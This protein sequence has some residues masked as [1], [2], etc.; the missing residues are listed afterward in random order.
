VQRRNQCMLT[1]TAPEEQAEKITVAVT[2]Y[3]IRKYIGRCLNSVI[4]QSWLNLEIIVIDDGSTDGSENICDAFAAADPRIRVIHT[5]NGGPGQARNRAIAASTGAYVAFVDGD[6]YIEPQMYEIM[7][8]G[9]KETGADLSV[10]RYRCVADGSEQARALLTDVPERPADTT[11]AELPET[12]LVQFSR[13]ELLTELVEESD[14]YP[15]RNAVWNKLCRRELIGKLRLPAQMYYEDILFTM[16]L[17]AGAGSAC[18]IDTPLY[19]Y[20]ID[21]KGSIMNQGV[22]R[23][24]LTDQIPAY[25]AKEAFLSSIGREDLARTH[26]YLVCKKLLLLYTEARRSKDPEKQASLKALEKVIRTS[27]KDRR[28]F[29]CRIADPH[30]KLRMDL[31]QISPLLY[32]AFMDVNDG[33]VMPLRQAMK[34]SPAGRNGE[35]E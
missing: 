21:R 3:N 27:V 2:C 15:I 11:P 16:Q 13:D 10:C 25:D 20:I 28:I 24:I 5:E 12:D 19:N 23:G 22:N 30:Q 35:P 31:F 18:F 14:R 9:M 34:K 7:L 17:L 1:K 33:L 6:D 4:R 29:S 8:A 26:R 32:D